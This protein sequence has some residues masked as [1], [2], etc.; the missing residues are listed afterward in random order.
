MGIGD[1]AR[2]T[3]NP[4]GDGMTYAED[5]VR[6]AIRYAMRVAHT[7]ADQY[8]ASD[9]KVERAAGKAFSMGAAAACEA[10]AFALKL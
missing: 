4:D 6:K 8:G 5:D 2:G 10:I 9:D 3:R 1:E 7:V